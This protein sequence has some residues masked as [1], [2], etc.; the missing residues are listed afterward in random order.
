LSALL[1]LPAVAFALK[2]YFPQRFPS[3]STPNI[4]HPT[5]RASCILTQGMHK[6]ANKNDNAWIDARQQHASRS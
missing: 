6:P 3:I 2:D 1:A 5:F 4:Q